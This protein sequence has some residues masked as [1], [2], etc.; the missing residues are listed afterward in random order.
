VK[1]EPAGDRARLVVADRGP[2]IPEDERARI[3]VRFYRVSN[4]ET[5]RTRG[6]GIGLAIVRDFADQSGATITIDDTPGGGATFVVDFPSRPDGIA[7]GEVPTAER[8][9]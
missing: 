1:V 4:A 3:F 6:A 9:P 2:G 8:I 5:I 7:S